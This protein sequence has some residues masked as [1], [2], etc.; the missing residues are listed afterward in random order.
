MSN[1][2]FPTLP[3][4]AWSVG[5]WPEFSTLVKQAVNGAETRIAMWS[6]PRWHFK[7]KYELLRDDA[8]NEL[9][10]LAGFFLA[11]QGQ[12]DDF[13]F[14][15]PDDNTVTG[16]ALGSGDGATTTFQCVRSFGGFVEP[17]RA[18]DTTQPM[19]V[20]VGGVALSASAWSVSAT[21]LITFATAPA[22]AAAIS[23][24]FSYCFRVRFDA[25]QLEFEQFMHQLWS[26]ETCDL[27]SV[28]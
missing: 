3:G 12:Y 23:A 18:I 15:D 14:K 21:G 5:K 25:D 26:L 28:K 27:V 4:M 6:S 7:L 19:N 1:L 9:K 2:M 20:Y 17:V 16:Q 24:D 11:R 22:A 10:T 13:L 8:T